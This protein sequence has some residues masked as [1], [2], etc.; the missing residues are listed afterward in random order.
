MGMNDGIQPS[1]FLFV[2]TT[3]ALFQTL[4][5]L[6]GM[7]QALACIR[8]PSSR[9]GEV[10]V[11]W[12]EEKEW[13]TLTTWTWLLCATWPQSWRTGTCS[14]QFISLG[15]VLDVWTS[16]EVHTL[17]LEVFKASS[18]L[19]VGNSQYSVWNSG[20]HWAPIW[21]RQQGPHLDLLELRSTTGCLQYLPPPY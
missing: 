2:G 12:G 3:L 15:L 16:T 21:I 6:P 11:Q 14:A 1:H 10:L 18:S 7:V 4:S 9:W 8:D 5:G 13:E 17:S 19:H 20:L